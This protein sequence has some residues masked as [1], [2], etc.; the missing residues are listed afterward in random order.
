M[1]LLFFSCY[2]WFYNDAPVEYNIRTK[3]QFIG[4][5]SCADTSDDDFGIRLNGCSRLRL[6]AVDAAADG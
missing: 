3:T 6:C 4:I 5:I 2:L 1:C